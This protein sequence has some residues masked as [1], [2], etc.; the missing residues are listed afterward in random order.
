M[1][2][3]SVGIVSVTLQL[4]LGVLFPFSSVYAFT[5]CVASEVFL[6]ESTLEL[7]IQGWVGF[8]MAACT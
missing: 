7:S 8:K 3:V 6:S 2:W 5:V 1:V 4:L